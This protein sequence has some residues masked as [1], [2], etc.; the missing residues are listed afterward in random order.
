MNGKPLRLPVDVPLIGAGPQKIQFKHDYID[1]PLATPSTLIRQTPEAIH[2]VSSG[3]LTKLEH[4]ACLIAASNSCMVPS[5]VV[6][7]A[8]EV[9]VECERRQ[10][11]QPSQ[12]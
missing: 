7:R 9:L 5:A 12:G 1:G 6:D 2:F 11:R 8:T 4:A 10:H 3:G